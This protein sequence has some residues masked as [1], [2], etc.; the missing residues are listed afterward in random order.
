MKFLL[1]IS[2]VLHLHPMEVPRPPL[3]LMTTIWSSI[4]LMESG[5]AGVASSV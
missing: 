5:V 1:I 2:K 3:S 4:S